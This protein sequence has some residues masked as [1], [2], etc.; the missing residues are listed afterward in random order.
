[1]RII[2]LGA[3]VQSSTMALMVKHGDLPPVDCA[4]F[5]DTGGEPQYVY[6]WLKKLDFILPYPI[7]RVT[8][9]N[10]LESLMGSRSGRFA[11]IPAF[12]DTKSGGMSR[13]QCTREYKISAIQKKV[14][15]LM[16]LQPHERCQE[17]AQILIGISMDE[18]VRMKPSGNGFMLNT[19]PLIDKN[20]TRQHCLHWLA[21]HGYRAPKKSAC[22]FCPYHDDVYWRDL[23]MNHPGDFANAVAV[24][25]AIRSGSRMKM[26]NKVYLHRSLTPLKDVDFRNAQDMGQVDAFNNECEGMCGV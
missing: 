1:M 19:F 17:P 13:R 23:K 15:E 20:M 7:H 4:I 2:S 3:G 6:D 25:E 22:T 24:D 8:N 10:L 11:S 5:A 16:G 14:R 12:I 9:G 21:G 18:V 26:D